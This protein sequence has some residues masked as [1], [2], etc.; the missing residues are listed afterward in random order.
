MI[1]SSVI[2]IPELPRGAN[3]KLDVRALRDLRPRERPVPGRR[4]PSTKTEQVVA[5]IWASVLGVPS[6]FADDDFFA[7]GGHSLLSMT[8]ADMVNRTFGVALP[9]FDLFEFRTLERLAERI[10]A[11]R[12]GL[13]GGIALPP[14][15]PSATAELYPLSFEQR[16]PWLGYNMGAEHRMHLAGGALVLDGRLDARAMCRAVEAIVERH[17]IL[18]TTFPSLSG[19]PMQKVHASGTYRLPTKS[20]ADLP[21]SRRESEAR[22]WAQDELG[23]PFDLANGPLLRFHLVELEPTRHWLL[24]TLHHS[25]VD[26]VSMGVFLE[27]L[28]A[29]YAAFRR[30][31]PSPL[32]P[33]RLQY[34]DYVAW[35]RALRSSETGE[36]LA[37]FWSDRLPTLPRLALP[38]DHPIP[39]P[40]THRGEVFEFVL[41]SARSDAI[42]E[43]AV[44]CGVSQALF[45]LTAYM[46]LL[47]GLAGQSEI[48][49][50]FPFAKRSRAELKLMLGAFATTLLVKADLPLDLSFDDALAR[51]RVGYLEAL[52]HAEHPLVEI[53]RDAS[54]ARGQVGYDFPAGEGAPVLDGLR[55]EQLAVY[56]RRD[57]AI[58]VLLAMSVSDGR[59]TGQWAYRTDLF[60]RQTIEG[61]HERL[62]QILALATTR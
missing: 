45:G 5:E 22:R 6:V 41:S 62:E 31:E 18:R 26:H 55:T 11:L 47:R 23:R 49:V 44:S 56:E 20:F 51:V 61:W 12:N 50:G 19:V 27:E 60:E 57:I 10:D 14:V 53:M 15:N 38:Y 2:S 7:L 54:S 32:P 17:E 16:I 8:I 25:L 24:L 52:E 28:G 9:L 29:L 59:I 43:Q 1:P 46:L 13:R 39:N 40:E 37:E 36:R 58:D 34:R 42:R 3:G 4:P 30:G 35:Q 21:A 33:P 48:V